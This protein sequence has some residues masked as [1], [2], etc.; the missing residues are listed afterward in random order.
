MLALRITLL[1]GLLG[2]TALALGVAYGAGSKAGAKSVQAQWDAQARAVAAS[3]LLAERAARETEQALAE[4]VI[5]VTQRFTHEKSLRDRAAV[6]AAGELRE[7]QA[8]LRASAATR[9]ARR[10]TAAPAGADGA[11]T[12]EL[13]LACAAE[14]QAMAAEA[15]AVAVRLTGLQDYVTQVL[16]KAVPS[17]L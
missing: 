6:S 9:G 5:E 13:L 2:G 16:A 17:G 14:H 4:R 10:D 3:V 12:S 11:S 7:L 8:A 15:D 1:A